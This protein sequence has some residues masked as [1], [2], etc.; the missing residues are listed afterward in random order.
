MRNF[1]WLSTR[2]GNLKCDGFFLL[3]HWVSRTRRFFVFLNK[4]RT[5]HVGLRVRLFGIILANNLFFHPKK[6]VF[7][8]LDNFL[9]IIRISKKSVFS[10]FD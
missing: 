2:N 1:F 5:R 6:S 9:K 4:S 8:Y 7:V 10:F 3:G